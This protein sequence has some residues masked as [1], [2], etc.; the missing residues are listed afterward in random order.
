MVHPMLEGVFNLL[1]SWAALFAGFLSDERDDKPNLLPMLPTVA[2]M[3][4]LTSAFLLPY[5]A[6]RTSEKDTNNVFQE[7][8]S[9]SAR[10]VESRVLGL[11]LGLVGGSAIA[12]GALAREADF[13]GWSERVASFWQLMS[14]DRVGS[15]F[16]VDFAIFAVFQGWLV[17]DDMKRRGGSLAYETWAEQGLLRNVAKCVPFFGLVFYLTVRPTFPSRQDE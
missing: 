8:L 13:G 16:L 4:F 14:M 3:Q 10:L 15:S 6:T 2:G 7:D 12:W 17:D 11:F 9:P 1:L 5:L